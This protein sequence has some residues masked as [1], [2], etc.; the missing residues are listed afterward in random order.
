[1]H[2]FLKSVRAAFPFFAISF[3][4]SLLLL[5]GRIDVDFFSF[6][7]GGRSI[8]WGQHLYA[9]VAENKGPITYLFFAILYQLFHHQYE[10]ALLFASTLIDGFNALFLYR[11]IHRWLQV[12]IQSKWQMYF[13]I[14]SVLYIKSFSIN[15]LQGG[16]YSEQ[17][18]MTF[19]LGS[20]LLV[21]KDYIFW[22][23]LTFGAALLTRQSFIFYLI[24]ITMRIWLHKNKLQKLSIFITGTA[25]VLSI[26]VF[27]LLYLHQEYWAYENMILSVIWHSQ[28][29][30]SVY[31]HYLFLGIT[32][33]SRLF[34]ALFF[35][36]IFFMKNKTKRFLLFGLSISGAACIFGGALIWDHHFIQLAPA[37][38]TAITAAIIYK[39]NDLLLQGIILAIAIS[40]GIGYVSYATIGTKQG[41]RLADTLPIMPEIQ[42]KRY[43]IVF[44]LY[45]C[46]YID[47]DKS[48]PDRYYD[49]SFS[50]SK[51][52][53]GSY[54]NLARTRHL[55]L[56]KN[57][58][59]QT[60]FVMLSLVEEKTPEYQWYLDLVHNQ[61]HLKKTAEYIQG[62]QHIEIY[63]SL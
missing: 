36:I 28:A 25:T 23:G 13:I 54:A 3:L 6:Y 62:E 45:A 59:N 15:S 43:M 48:A 31:F 46:L 41:Q 12:N 4:I 24:F 32:R 57:R 33:E 10:F 8:I 19:L 18:G 49:P 14:M 16:I 38:L 53:F 50:L 44:P 63:E 51:Y 61:F 29:T 56:D 11:L 58:L 7:Y 60:A 1:M 26:G 17:I 39:K 34:F 35:L 9:D 27:L 21:E 20:L 47:Y 40:V 52:Y 22:A 55:H 5:I 42:K 30:R 2:P 37:F